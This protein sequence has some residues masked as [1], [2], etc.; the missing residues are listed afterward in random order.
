MKQD[1]HG[2]AERVAATEVCFRKSGLSSKNKDTLFRFER[3]LVVKGLTKARV[4]KY[5]E[6]LKRIGMW[7][8]KDFETAT[9]DDI[10]QVMENVE[11]ANYS[12]WTR[13]SYRVITKRFYKWLLKTEDGYPENVRWITTSCKRANIEPLGRNKLLTENDIQTLL[14]HSCN[15][16]DKAL[17]SILWESGCRIGEIATLHVRNITFDEYGAVL[18]VNGK[19]GPRQVRIVNAASHLT[20][21]LNTHP[22]RD[23][24]DAPIWINL[25]QVNRHQQMDYPAIRKMLERLFD[26]AGIKKPSNP[27]IFRHSRA[28]FMANHLTEFQMNHYFGWVQGSNMPSTYVH[29]SGKD[30]EAALLRANGVHIEKTQQEALLK[31]QTCPKCQLINSHDNKFCTRCGGLLD[32]SELARIQEERQQLEQKRTFADGIMNQLLADPEVQALIKTKMMAA[33]AV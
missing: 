12:A 13:V 6:T 32:I 22:S 23:D 20:L 18:Q 17:V 16:R 3:E 27:H 21:W 9:R 24:T 30:L 15:L 19:T 4:V 29:L 8:A 26:K 2:Y 7:L 11:K 31:P 14:N 1:W 10:I 33:R 25:G 28:T 5:L